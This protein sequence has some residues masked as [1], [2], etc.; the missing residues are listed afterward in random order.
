VQKKAMRVFVALVV[1]ASVAVAIRITAKEQREFTAFIAKH[2]RHYDSA[3]E[4]KL[5]RDIFAENVR[6]INKVNGEKRSYWLSINAFTDMSWDEFRTTHLMS[7]QNCSATGPG[8]HKRSRT[9]PAP[10]KDWRDAGVVS[11]VKDQGNCGSCWTFS[12]TG[13]VE[14]AHAIAHGGSAGL[15][16]LSEQQLID[17]AQAFGNQGCNGGLPSQAFQYIMAN[18][19]IDTEDSYSYEGQDDTC[20]FD[21]SHV[22]AM[23]TNQVNITMNDEDGIVDAVSNVGPVSVC[24]DVVSDFQSYSGGV[25][26]STECQ[27]DPQS[28]NHAVLAVGYNTDDSGTPYWIIKNSWGPSWGLSGYFYMQRGANMCGV[29]ACASYPISA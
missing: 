14:S 29:A 9:A 8:N 17:C 13:A 4:Y 25:Y 19:G 16:T 2:D 26:T 27:S 15:V 1:L 21:A 23:L 7:S 5:R 10:S 11:E 3:A 12:T 22:G 24:F 20:R 18:K 6:R 28:V